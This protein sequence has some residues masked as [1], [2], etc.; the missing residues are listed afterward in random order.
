MG[1]KKVCDRICLCRCIF[2]VKLLQRGDYGRFTL[3]PSLRSRSQPVM[4][5]YG[6]PHFL[7]VSAFS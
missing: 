7:E 4:G 2:T 6:S 3:G 1:D 5:I